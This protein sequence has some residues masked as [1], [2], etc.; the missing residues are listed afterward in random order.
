MSEVVQG[1]SCENP[2]VWTQ[3]SQH[4]P[5]NLAWSLNGKVSPG[6]VQTN[7]ALDVPAIALPALLPEFCDKVNVVAVAHTTQGDAVNFTLPWVPETNQYELRQG[8]RDLSKVVLYADNRIV[9][10]LDYNDIAPYD[11]ERTILTLLGVLAFTLLWVVL[12]LGMDTCYRMGKRRKEKRESASE[13]GSSAMTK[14]TST[15]NSVKG[16][17][18]DEGFNDPWR[19]TNELRQR[20][21]RHKRTPPR[22]KKAIREMKRGA[23]VK[24]RTFLP[25]DPMAVA[26]WLETSVCHLEDFEEC[27]GVSLFDIAKLIHAYLLDN[28]KPSGAKGMSWDL[29]DWKLTDLIRDGY[30]FVVVVMAELL[31]QG[32]MGSGIF[33]SRQMDATSKL[34][35][36]AS[37]GLGLV[38]VLPFMMSMSRN[39]SPYLY[40]MVLSASPTVLCRDLTGGLVCLIPAFFLSFG[41]GMLLTESPISA[42]FLSLISVA[43]G[44]FMLLIT[45]LYLLRVPDPHVLLPNGRAPFFLIFL[46]LI[47]MVPFVLSM[48]IVIE[49]VWIWIA[50]HAGS[51]LAAD[52]LM[53]RKIRVISMSWHLW[54]PSRLRLAHD[55]KTDPK[56]L[57]KLLKGLTRA[58]REEALWVV[59]RKI[60]DKEIWK[61]YAETETQGF[62]EYY[63]MAMEDLVKI[64]AGTPERRSGE[65]FDGN[66]NEIIHGVLYFLILG[67]SAVPLYFEEGTSSI[68]ARGVLYGMVAFLFGAGTIELFVVQIVEAKQS[69]THDLLIPA[70][71]RVVRLVEAKMHET[72]LVSYSSVIVNFQLTALRWFLLA[73]ICAYLIEPA[74]LFI[75][76]PFS[77]G[78]N[79]VLYAMVSRMFLSGFAD[80]AHVA[81]IVAMV[82]GVFVMASFTIAS[83]FTTQIAPLVVV[84]C[85]MIRGLRFVSLTYATYDAS[86]PLIISNLIMDLS[87]T[88]IMHMVLTVSLSILCF[89]GG[90]MAIL[91]INVNFFAGIQVALPASSLAIFA[92][93]ILATVL[94]NFVVFG[95]APLTRICFRRG[96]LEWEEVVEYRVVCFLAFISG[97]VYLYLSALSLG[98]LLGF[99][100]STI[101]YAHTMRHLVLEPR[102]TWHNTIDPNDI[103]M[104]SGKRILDGGG[105]TQVQPEV[106]ELQVADKLLKGQIN[107]FPLHFDNTGLGYNVLDFV[108]RKRLLF[109]KSALH[110]IIPSEDE[111]PSAFDPED[112]DYEGD[113]ANNMGRLERLRGQTPLRGASE[114]VN[115]QK[116]NRPNSVASKHGEPSE[117][118]TYLQNVVYSLVNQMLEDCRGGNVVVHLCQAHEMAREGFVAMGIRRKDAGNNTGIDQVR[119][120]AYRNSPLWN[121]QASNRLNIYI[122]VEPR[123]IEIRDKPDCDNDMILGY[124]AEI[125]LHEYVED[126]TRSH[127]LACVSELA[128]LDARRDGY[129]PRNTRAQLD[130]MARTST[131]RLQ[132]V[133]D[134]TEHELAKRNANAKRL[135]VGW[136]YDKASWVEV[137]NVE[138]ELA[139]EIGDYCETLIHKG[140]GLCT[141]LS[142]VFTCRLGVFYRTINA[143]T[144]SSLR[145]WYTALRGDMEVHREVCAYLRHHDIAPGCCGSFT[146]L[147]FVHRYLARPLFERLVKIFAWS[148]SPLY[149]QMFSYG[150]TKRR[151]KLLPPHQDLDLGA[152]TRKA[153]RQLK[154]EARPI[155]F[156][157][158]KLKD[159]GQTLIPGILAAVMDEMIVKNMRGLRPYWKERMAMVRG[160]QRFLKFSRET[161]RLVEQL[162]MPSTTPMHMNTLCM[163][164]SDLLIMGHTGSSP[165]TIYKPS[166]DKVDVVVDGSA[167]IFY[168]SGGVTTCLMQLINHT[169]IMEKFNLYVLAEVASFATPRIACPTKC[170]NEIHPIPL[171][172]ITPCPEATIH[173]NRPYF[174]L[175]QRKERTTSWVLRARFHPLL[176]ELIR[177]C[178]ELQGVDDR[179]SQ[180]NEYFSE[181]VVAL[182]EYF[183]QYDWNES[184]SDGLTWQVWVQTWL[185]ILEEKPKSVQRIWAPSLPGLQE[186]L[187]FFS[188]ALR[189]LAAPLP[190]AD[191]YHSSHHGIGALKGI[192]HKQ[193]FKSRFIVW[194]HG[195]LLRERLDQLCADDQLLNPFTRNAI[196]GLTRLTARLV[197]NSAD[198]I[199]PC[200][201]VDMYRKWI[202]LIAGR[203]YHG[204]FFKRILPISNGTEP[205]IDK[206]KWKRI[207]DYYENPELQAKDEEPVM[208]PDHV[209]CVMLSHVLPI[210]DVEN[211]IRA[212]HHIVYNRGLT[213]Y[214]LH[215]F[216]GLDKD[217]KY[218]ARCKS[219]LSELNLRQYVTLH[220]AAMKW[221]VFPKADLFL[222]S[223]FSEG[224]PMA[225]LEAE[226]AKV[227]VVC[228]DVGGSRQV[229][230]DDRCRAPPRDPV[231]LGDAE[232]LTLCGFIEATDDSQLNEIALS[233]R[234]REVRRKH[235]EKMF[236]F[237]NDKHVEQDTYDKHFD[238]MEKYA[239]SV[240]NPSGDSFNP[241]PFSVALRQNINVTVQS[242]PVLPL[243]GDRRNAS[244]T[245]KRVVKADDPAA[246]LNRLNAT[247]V[248]STTSSSFVSSPKSELR[249]DQNLIRDADSSDD[250]GGA[251]PSAIQSSSMSIDMDYLR[252]IRAGSHH[253]D[254][255]DMD[256]TVSRYSR[257]TEGSRTSTSSRRRLFQNR[258]NGGSSLYQPRTRDSTGASSRSYRYSRRL[259]SLLRY[260]PA[261]TATTSQDLDS[262]V[263]SGRGREGTLSSM[264]YEGRGREDSSFSDIE[265]GRMT[266]GIYQPSDTVQPF[267]GQYDD[268]LGDSDN[269]SM[270]K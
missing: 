113:Q 177:G 216:G 63:Y 179:S 96:L 147:L 43:F 85:L 267:S 69:E 107:T 33:N 25:E 99:L 187:M 60:P 55:M 266:G 86:A 178:C 103:P 153:F 34:M 126:A 54:L 59:N 248:T 202:C 136:R 213:C 16:D 249:P 140:G 269:D 38:S 234:A 197:Y 241:P 189:S 260:D 130:L 2:F 161:E 162:M 78:Y 6:F 251:T 27:Y 82:I 143:L 225:I 246:V 210:K 115:S 160:R 47:L 235:A 258:Q 252:N 196:I 105:L 149:V 204:P 268:F 88:T 41:L 46:V 135:P 64:N 182:Y 195:I 259:V 242:A 112:S 209:H 10:Q 163:S 198:I 35:T 93:S 146:T 7:V 81:V 49:E 79:L 134:Q 184:W 152:G 14:R 114:S 206:L 22:Q 183:E 37:L 56:T 110:T 165:K 231:S 166:S 50:I 226:M 84:T 262:S 61:V 215:I 109:K 214:R 23:L 185:S 124:I 106:R 194:D 255:L 158:F 57:A 221:F 30:F 193:R 236:D 95:F 102:N 218:V 58:Q 26:V 223:S 94:I 207:E 101:I 170:V 36:T 45:M 230:P 167:T 217:P 190:P 29:P 98:A 24:F 141:L 74:V 12:Y 164:A 92:S 254:N 222:N 253:P 156:Q 117:G 256:D 137:C 150:C 227:P 263:I 51:I 191:L 142:S 172:D 199:S 77:A 192:V 44:V 203:P 208:D 239:T 229:V 171:H 129:L 155:L 68:V 123:V 154:A 104:T 176:R 233:D 250:E 188:Q 108:D 238:L 111:D 220:G 18:D 80:R 138:K 175:S 245:P 257:A 159:K 264:G 66:A 73:T 240:E 157:V 65:L 21:N 173:A 75:T 211:A 128:M 17:T 261:R 62:W 28:L 89:W 1:V 83:M 42:A 53:I 76:L 39:V 232:I 9:N 145:I 120:T 52:L 32:F 181:V 91:N 151:I 119:G 224:L 97:F 70:S 4:V 201:N 265:T 11:Y 15:A 13:G 174:E 5:T 122:G 127:A 118:N 121:E 212:A 31:L 71:K 200:T 87:K 144:R 20:R 247:D 131:T 48:T 8:V 270:F 133:Y 243:Q 148:C 40:Q 125:I 180:V 72:R 186:A 168:V 90:Q 116:G 100:T 3:G 228:T 132:H 205:L 169:G 244:R 67:F 19:N 139:L 219:V 237:A